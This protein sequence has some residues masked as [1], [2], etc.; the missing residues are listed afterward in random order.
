VAAEDVSKYGIVS[1][2]RIDD[3]TFRVTTMIEKPKASEAPSRFAIPG[4][5]IVDSSVF[6]CIAET[7]PGR[8][9][10]IQFTDALLSLAQKKGLIAYQ[11]EGDRY[12]T[13]DRLGYLDATLTFGLRRPELRDGLMALMKKHLK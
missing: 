9:G 10:E 4:R 7:K 3:R 2:T 6:D 11:F 8:N 12:D 5:Y 13:G 1:G